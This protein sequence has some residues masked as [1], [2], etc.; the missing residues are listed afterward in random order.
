MFG[1]GEIEDSEVK[2]RY[3]KE[4]CLVAFKGNEIILRDTLCIEQRNRENQPT[5][6]PPP[7]VIKSPTTDDEPEP[8]VDP[9]RDKKVKET[10]RMKF[11]LP[12]GQVSNMLGVIN[13]IQS[14]F[15]SL[16]NELSAKGGVI[17]DQEYE[18][19]ILEAFSQLGIDLED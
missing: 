7:V 5:P 19:K 1:L 10:L 2:Y 12:K 13:Y 14:K 18:D 16:E 9:K 3:F 8:T 6:G 11:E 4:E 15:Q 17:T